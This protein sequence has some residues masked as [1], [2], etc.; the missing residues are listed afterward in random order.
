MERVYV[1]I[2][3]LMCLPGTV[4]KDSGMGNACQVQVDFRLEAR[5]STDHLGQYVGQFNRSG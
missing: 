2:K 5:N 1:V 4:E 3:V